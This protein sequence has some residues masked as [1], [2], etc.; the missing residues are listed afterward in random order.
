MTSNELTLLD[1]R[2]SSRHRDVAPFMSESEFFDLYVAE[3]VLKQY[4]VNIDALMRG[5]VDGE[6][7]CGIDGFYC[8]VNDQPLVSDLGVEG[9]SR[10]PKI[11]C[12]IT[13]CKTS[14]GFTEQVI[15][16]LNYNLPRLLSFDRSEASLAQHVNQQLLDVTR[17]FLNYCE[18]A[19]P[20]N[21]RITFNIYYATRAG[22]VHP[23]A[24][25]K[26]QDVSQLLRRTLFPGCFATFNFLGARELLAYA[27]RSA[28]TVRSLAFVEGPLTSE[29]EQGE[30]YVCLVRLSDYFR[31]ILDENDNSLN[32]TLFESNV[33]DHEGQTDVNVSIRKTLQNT[34]SEDFWW[35][36]NG[37]TIVAP[38][39]S[40]MGKKLHITDAQVVNGLQTS[41]EVYNFFS[42][43][44]DAD[45]S[46]QILVRV[47]V[48]RDG[49]A[50][51][52]IIRATN[53][54][55]RL[56]G[57]ALRATDRIQHNIEEYFE[58]RGFYYDRRKNYYANQGRPLDRIISMESLA[59]S[60]A[61]C[62]LREPWISR[63]RSS[64]ILDDELYERMFSE[65][66]PLNMYLNVTLL[67]RRVKE[68]LAG[69]PQI[70]NAN[71]YDWLFH[72][73]TVAAMLL[74]NKIKPSPKDLANTTLNEF[75]LHRIHDLVPVVAREYEKKIRDKYVP[76]ALVAASRDVSN[77]LVKRAES[78]LQSSRWR[79]WPDEPMQEDAPI[80][81]S[82]VFYRGPRSL[83]R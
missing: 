80:L 55:N 5:L 26:A 75:D 49:L 22:E 36:N 45:G 14:T 57:S 12:V 41:T 25:S 64:S 76:F 59:Q 24:K 61:A 71:V 11:D 70:G 65:K 43:N 78:M 48:P 1:M 74:T 34:D 37:V 10:N 83:N 3:Q 30:G 19:A 4:Q 8:F 32:G 77:A 67:T 60:V 33:R 35:L 44:P 54:Q 72:V 21:P 2:I 81:T 73:S 29:S 79:R 63:S 23:N 31:F 15:E 13:Q 46:R 27:Q 69:H 17:V 56:P 9:L 62:Y 6:G 66:M 28:Q 51:D 42:C 20:L 18:K 58:R 50:R 39:V 82:D 7:D 47:V 40:Q 68:G 53:N 16:K 52:R 38:N